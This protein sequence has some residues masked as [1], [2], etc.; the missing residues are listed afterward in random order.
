[1]SPA[2]PEPC[3]ALA[4]RIAASQEFRRAK[5]LRA[6]LSYV[7]DRHLAGHPEELTETQI[8]HRVFS[9]PLDYN[10]GD[11]SIVRTEARN[12]RLRLERYF[13]GEGQD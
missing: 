2:T 5:R 8:G 9:R 11:D 3:R 13:S 4:E 1:V 7:V 12:L 6:F 10:S